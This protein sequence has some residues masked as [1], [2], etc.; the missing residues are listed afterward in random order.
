MEVLYLT[1]RT[2]FGEKVVSCIHPR[3][4]KQIQNYTIKKTF[5]NNVSLIANVPGKQPPLHIEALARTCEGMGKNLKM[6]RKNYLDVDEKS[7][8]KAK[9][10][11]FMPKEK[12]KGGTFSPSRRPVSIA[13]LLSVFHRNVPTAQSFSPF[14]SKLLGRRRK[15][16]WCGG[17]PV[18][19]SVVRQERHG[20]FSYITM[21][22]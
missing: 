22:C 9:V 11:S 1:P 6:K 8:S 21:R 2:S 19:R 7:K 12:Q 16:L 13:W 5:N 15:T 20:G 14:F 3:V 4:P 10:K 18:S 17:V